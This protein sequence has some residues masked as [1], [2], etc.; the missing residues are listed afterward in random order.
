MM[1][2]AIARKACYCLEWRGSYPHGGK[3]FNLMND[4]AAANIL[5]SSSAEVWQIPA[6]VYC[7]P[8]VG[9]A[10]L[11]YKVAPGGRSGIPIHTTGGVYQ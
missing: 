10:E 2:P 6:D 5:F 4:I 9:L 7:K 8:K 3:E 1:E 11:Q